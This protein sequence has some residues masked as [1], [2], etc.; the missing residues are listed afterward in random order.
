MID[1]ILQKTCNIDRNVIEKFLISFI[2]K[3]VIYDFEDKNT[4][5][6]FVERNKNIIQ[7]IITNEYFVVDF[8]FDILNLSPV[9]KNMLIVLYLNSNDKDFL[10]I[11]EEILFKN[12]QSYD[13][14]ILFNK[15]L[16]KNY[17]QLMLWLN[18]ESIRYDKVKVYEQ[19]YYSKL[20]MLNAPKEEIRKYSESLLSNLKIEKIEKEN[21]VNKN[22]SI[23]GGLKN[24]LE[25]NIVED[26]VK[27]IENNKNSIYFIP[28]KRFDFLK[29]SFFDIRIPN[30]I[31]EFD[32]YKKY[33]NKEISEFKFNNVKHEI[34]VK[35]L[36]NELDAEKIGEVISLLFDISL[37]Y[38]NKDY[39]KEI[40]DY[41]LNSVNEIKLFGF[42][43][44]SKIEKIKEVVLDR[45]LN[46]IESQFLVDGIIDRQVIEEKYRK[47]EEEKIVK[48][49]LEN[50]KIEIIN[51]I[52]EAFENEYK[53]EI[54]FILNKCKDIK[55][56]LVLFLLNLTSYKYILYDNIVYTNNLLFEKIYQLFN[57][58]EKVIHKEDIY[59]VIKNST[60]KSIVYSKKRKD[61]KEKSDENRFIEY[62]KKVNPDKIKTKY[63]EELL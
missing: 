5:K 8:I 60:K 24:L 41:I 14:Y 35:D 45:K 61:D 12:N 10:N 52:V 3:N 59:S 9:E 62:L 50:F 31:N 56:L 40:L 6:N 1:I 44:Y 26:I 2:D 36:F 23:E 13:D 21:V 32:F 30:S 49:K 54:S 38:K 7:K 17:I 19:F 18:S 57:L 4:I 63:L 43:Y 28:E 39:I 16:F 29:Y 33:I 55:I 58:K 20:Y 53:Q 27:Q 47:I 37:S 46:Y 34:K 48:E 22:K 51:K 42:I 11:S 25:I 15:Q